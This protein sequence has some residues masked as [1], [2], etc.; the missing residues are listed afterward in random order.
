MWTR[1]W[2]AMPA[3]ARRRLDSRGRQETCVGSEGHQWALRAR[4][5]IKRRYSSTLPAAGPLFRGRVG[6]LLRQCLAPSRGPLLRAGA[7]KARRPGDRETHAAP[8]GAG[9]AHV[10]A[11]R[12]ARAPLSNGRHHAPAPFEWP[13]PRAGP[14]PLTPASQVASPESPT[15]MIRRRRSD[16]Q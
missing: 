8:G 4:R 9:V 3:A 10:P 2:G 12:R 15:A 1:S 11:R 16:L 6:P 13:T 7:S 14:M 5:R